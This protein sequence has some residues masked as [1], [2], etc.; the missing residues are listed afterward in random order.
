MAGRSPG[1]VTTSIGLDGHRPLRR[2]SN[3][4]TEPHK[5]PLPRSSPPPLTAGPQLHHTPAGR[6]PGAPTATYQAHK[7]DDQDVRGRRP[8]GPYGH[9]YRDRVGSAPAEP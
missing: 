3:P 7:T 2:S 8:Q 4:L 9:R 1:S 5:W 6:L